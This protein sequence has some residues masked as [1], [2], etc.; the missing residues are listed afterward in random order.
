[1]VH[2]ADDA[3][4]PYPDAVEMVGWMKRAGIDVV[5]RWVTE[6]DLDGDVYKSSGHPLGDRTKIVLREFADRARKGPSDFDRKEDVRYPTSNGAFVISYAG[7]PPVGRF[8]PA[9]PTP[10]YPDHTDL[11]HYRAPEPR[12]IKAV[13]DWEVRRRH[14]LEGMQRVMG[15]LPGPLRRVPLDAK[16]VE[17]KRVGTHLRRK[18]TYQSD[19]G[20]RVPAYLFVPA[21]RPAKPLPAVLCLHQTTA[22]G[23]DE[24]AGLRGDADLKYALELAERGYVV[25]APDYPSL[26]EHAFDFKART[27]YASGTMKAIWDN[28]RAVDLL[29]TVPE[30]DAGRVGVIGHSLGGHGAMFTAAFDPRLRAVVS[31]CGFTTFRKDDV[32]SWTGPRYMPRIRAE[33]GSDAKR[34]P[35]DFQEVVAAFAPRPFLAVA[36]EKDDDFD[37]SGVRD[38]IAAARPVYRLYGADA[39]L[40]ALYPPGKHAFPAAAR[41]RAYEFLDR[42]L[43]R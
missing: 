9:A 42:H 8:E 16:V 22:A 33:F 12:P 32:P 30:A 10:A 23:K 36:A 25:L 13:K 31:S 35:F 1:V 37:V 40:E 3:T 34:V 29:E 5:P 6:K 27:D 26:G 19:P 2:G 24:P 15:P 21:E 11:T 18:L 7:G 28:V 38:V 17:E 4:C 39:A 41:K 20:G 14:V 43:G